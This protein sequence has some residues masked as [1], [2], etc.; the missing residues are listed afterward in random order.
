MWISLGAG[1]MKA[2]YCLPIILKFLEEAKN[3]AVRWLGEQA[4]ATA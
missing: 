2:F 1:K 4:I 3:A